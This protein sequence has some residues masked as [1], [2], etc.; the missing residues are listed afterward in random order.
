MATVKVYTPFTFLNM[1]AGAKWSY[2]WNNL[3]DA[4]SASAYS[5]DISPWY[6]GSY[7]E[8]YNGTVKAEFT[9]QRRHRSIEKKGSIGVT[10]EEHIDVL[11]TITNLGPNKADV[12]FH[13]I[14]FI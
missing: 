2:T 9:Y 14:S 3:P 5:V 12:D 8:G 1:P 4:F 13:I 6:L 7:Q 11:G 10:V